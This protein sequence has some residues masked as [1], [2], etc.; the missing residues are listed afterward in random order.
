M[1]YK[2]QIASLIRTTIYLIR[3]YSYDKFYRSILKRNNITNKTSK[4]EK[5]WITKWSQLGI[6]AKP[7]QYRVFRQYIGDDINIVPEDICH[8]YIET[9]LNPMRFR[10]YYAD[11]NTFDKLFPQGYFPKTLLR[12]ICG[13]YYSNDYRYLKM[14]E[15]MLQYC[16]TKCSTNR[17]I[18]KPSVDGMSGRGVEAYVRGGG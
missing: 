15:A 10:G 11:K 4:D 2:K 16:L 18:I 7:T 5:A 8:N 14:D 3:Q 13:F 12:K 17:I 1:K 6:K 9:I